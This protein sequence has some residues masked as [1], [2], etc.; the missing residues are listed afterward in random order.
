MPFIAAQPA[1]DPAAEAA[2]RN[3]AFWPDIDPADC[4]EHLRIDGTVTAARLRG[5][6]IEAIAHV[7]DQLNAWRREQMNAGHA[8]LDQVPADNIDGRSALCVRYV[9]AV[10]CTAAAQ[11]TERLRHFDATGKAATLHTQERI[12][13]TA[14]DYRREAQ[15]ALRDIRGQHRA[16]IDL[17]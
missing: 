8:A 12:D 1:P 10:Y 16:L 3:A 7:N 17:V 4:R 9:R 2:I 13:A 11:I 15:W 5:A 6:L 14:E